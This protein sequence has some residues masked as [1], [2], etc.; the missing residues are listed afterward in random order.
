MKALF[1]GSVQWSKDALCKCFEIGI[2][3]VGVVGK[4]E[5]GINSD[6]IDIGEVCRERNV[7]IFYDSNINAQ[8]TLDWVK[9][10]KPDVIFCFGWSH[11]LK[12]EILTV[13]SLGVIGFHPA[14]LPMNRGRHPLI[15]ALALGLEQTASTF[16]FMDEGID[17]GDIISQ[18]IFPIYYEDNAA[19][20]YAKM[21]RVALS[22]MEKFIPALANGSFERIQQNHSKANIWRKR[23]KADGCIDFRMSSRSVYNLVR[24]LSRPYSGAHIEKAGSDYKVWE[25]REEDIQLKNIEPGKIIDV[26]G[27]LFTV[28]CGI[29]AV[30]I[31]EHEFA[32]PPK[33]GEYL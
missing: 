16:F 6:F 25:V 24:A 7:A 32:E 18:Q 5:D 10:K 15:W 12:N 3:I 4:H 14:E 22:Q 27:T 33:L 31:V 13:P 9:S 17:S 28:K 26:K 11:L 29:G 19:S 8:H 23:N 2:E 30:S 20:L 21:T 1:V